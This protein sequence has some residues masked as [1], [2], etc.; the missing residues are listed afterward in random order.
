M[1]QLG[2]KAASE[3]F[4]PSELLDLVSEAEQ[5]GFDSISVSDHFHP[6]RNDGVACFFVWSWLG[7]VG[8][9]T[10]RIQF[11]TGVTS[12][13]LRYNPAV[14]AEAAATL[15][16]MFPGRFWLGLGTGEALNDTATTGY[17]PGYAERRARLIEAIEIMRRLWAGEHLTYNGRYFQT[18]AAHVYLP[19]QAEIP[20]IVAAM[21]P[22][23]ARLAGRYADGWLATG[24]AGSSSPY[25][26]LMPSVDEGARAARRDPASVRRLI[27]IEV[28]YARDRA[29]GIKD[30][31]LWAGTL[32]R[33]RDKYGVYD[34]RDLQYYGELFPDQMIEQN[35]LISDD[36]DQHV[37]V[38]ERYIQMGF[39]HLFFHDPGRDQAA[40]LEFYG[41][42]VLP[43]LRQK[44]G[45]TQAA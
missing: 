3:Q 45:S 22:S 41:Q 10:R 7:A 13:I 6:W 21:G 25:D 14:L 35:W 23:S 30:A 34:P 12:P 38:A 4:G 33:D 16:A 17:W 32:V 11:G 18:R 36:P 15:G 40:F 9:R 28:V 27:E 2:Y 1:L 26:K 39:T 42:H 43:K 29:Q 8:A 44:Y 19:P 20:L 24:A 37:A 31:R 5:C